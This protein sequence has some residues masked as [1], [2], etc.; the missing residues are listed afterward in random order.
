[1]RET[2]AMQ[3]RSIRVI[4]ADNQKTLAQRRAEKDGVIVM[5][6]AKAY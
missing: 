6:E 3:N 5:S 4:E 2:N 1:M